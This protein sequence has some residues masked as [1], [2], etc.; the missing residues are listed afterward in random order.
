MEARV[1]QLQLLDLMIEKRDVRVP[2]DARAKLEL[3]DLMASILVAVFEAQERRA[4]ESVL[5]QSQDQAG[6]SGAQSAGLLTA[7][8]RQAGAVEQG[9]SA[10]SV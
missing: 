4:D 1:V 6:A 9:E 2:V 10:P 5:V 8:E 7:V 3:I